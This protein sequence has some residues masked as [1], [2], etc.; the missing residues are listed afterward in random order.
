[1]RRLADTIDPGNGAPVHLAQQALIRCRPT[2]NAG[3]HRLSARASVERPL[4]SPRAGVCR[5]GLIT[6]AKA[7]LAAG[8]PEIGFAGYCNEC[9]LTGHDN[10]EPD[11]ARALTPRRPADTID[12]GNGRPV[13]P[14][15][16]P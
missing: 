2:T 10:A 12:L 7:F 3:F 15:R 8:E 1:L 5:G 13:H 6:L 14:L 16:R 11:P 4:A 9:A